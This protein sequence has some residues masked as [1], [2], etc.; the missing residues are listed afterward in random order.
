MLAQRLTALSVLVITFS[1]LVAAWAD[2]AN[3]AMACRVRGGAC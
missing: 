1:I 2:G 3:A